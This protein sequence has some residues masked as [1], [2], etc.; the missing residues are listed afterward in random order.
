M[1]YGTSAGLRFILNAYQA[2]SSRGKNFKLSITNANDGFDFDKGDF[3][4][5]PG[6]QYTYSVTASQVITTNN[7]DQMPPGSYF[8]N[9]LLFT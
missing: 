2:D 4:I 3:L 8:L 7:F 6:Y 5:E 1:G 9:F